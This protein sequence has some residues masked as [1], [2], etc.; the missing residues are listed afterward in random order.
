MAYFRKDEIYEEKVVDIN[1][2]GSWGQEG[3]YHYSTM[4]H[5]EPEGR[6]HY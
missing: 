2:I 6:Y 5:W 3:H 4:F 1:D